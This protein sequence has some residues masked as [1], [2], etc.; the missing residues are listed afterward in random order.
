LELADVGLESAPLDDGLRFAKTN[1]LIG[2]GD[3]HNARTLLS[4]L[5][6]LHPLE[7]GI[8]QNLALCEYILGNHAAARAQTESLYATGDRSVGVLRMLISS[9]HH[10]GLM[11]RGVEVADANK[12]IVRGDSAL[13]GACSLLYADDNRLADAARCAA[14]SLRENPRC[15]DALT[16]DATLKLASGETDS[17]KRIFDDILS[18]HPNNGRAWLGLGSIAMLDQDFAEAKRTLTRTVETMPQHVGS[19]HMLGWMHLAQGQLDDAE[20]VFDRAM[21]LNRNFSETH[22]ALASIAAMRG[23]TAKAQELIKVAYRLDADSLVARFAESVLA[24]RGGDQ[25][26]M[27]QLIGEGLQMV[28]GNNKDAFTKLLNKATQRRIH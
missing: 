16:T 19:W 1:A 2:R 13:A 22:G 26:K 10:L 15:I 21:E 12:Q 9:C 24:A 6:A 27:Q 7:A 23:E 18:N 20:K 4:E 25:A 28:A 14:Y 17:A 11:D 3:F 5:H 8:T